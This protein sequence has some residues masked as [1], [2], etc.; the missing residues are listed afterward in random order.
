M[1]HPAPGELVLAGGLAPVQLVA[2]PDSPTP[3][4]DEVAG[5]V[6][7]GWRGRSHLEQ[8]LALGS[9]PAAILMAGSTTEDV[10]VFS[11]L[12][13]LERG[14]EVRLPA[15]H[16]LDLPG[17]THRTSAV[18]RRRRLAAAI[19]WLSSV[20]GR[21]ITPASVQAACEVFAARDAL[22]RVVRDE[23]CSSGAR[24][25]GHAAIVA[26]QAGAALGPVRHLAL[27]RDLVDESFASAPAP[28]GAS[29]RLILSGSTQEE[30]WLYRALERDGLV[31]LGA[32]DQGETDGWT[33]V[34]SDPIG[35]IADRVLDHAGRSAA[36]DGLVVDA[37]VA[38]ARDHDVQTIVHAAWDGDEVAAW[39]AA[40]LTRMAPREMAVV[41]LA[42]APH[43]ARAEEFGSSWHIDDNR[44]GSTIPAAT[45]TGQSTPPPARPTPGA[46]A[47]GTVPRSRKVLAVTDEFSS[48]QREWFQEVTARVRAGEPFAV[49]GADY[50]HEILRAMDI[51]YVVTQWWSSIV[52][53]KRLTASN[54]AALEA[55]GYSTRVEAYSTQ[56][57][58]SHLADEQ[59][60]GG[61]P[62]PDILGATLGTAPTH[63][64]Y[65]AWARETGARY[66]PLERSAETRWRIPVDWWNQLPQQWEE[67]LEAERLD[68]L[69]DEMV[70]VVRGLEA[71]TGRRFD[72]SRFAEVLALANEQAAYYREARDL[73]AATVPAP[74]G[75]VDTMPATMVPQW[76]R[77]TE[78]A[79]D[80]ARSLRDE[81]ADRASRGEGVVPREQLR[82]M[83]VGR[84]LWGD[85]ALYQHLE[86]SHGAVFVWSM[87]LGLAADGYERQ[88]GEGQD[89]LRALASRFVTMGDEL[90]MP[91]WAGAWH[92]KEARQHAVD[93][94][95][96]I[97]DADPFV[98]RSL[99]KAGIPVLRL[100]IENLSTGGEESARRALERFV[101]GLDPAR[102]DPS[103]TGKSDRSTRP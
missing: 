99:E 14:G 27:L 1:G 66:Y 62:A 35:A 47:A 15:C 74:A 3:I 41:T 101:D 60:W 37:L 26:R 22:L 40:R 23:R 38:Q 51:P 88:C 91:T 48:Y 69:R 102:T 53:A 56:G 12:R 24:L 20:A 84:G 100:P 94:A 16:Y 96:A 59:P 46:S 50:P 95:V 32:H 10:R 90:R 31:V 76:H 97:A 67:T 43:S 30:P 54:G 58:A 11:V 44:A 68:L 77:G 89:P 21:E 85:T 65:T 36:S 57:L 71:Q 86:Q 4:L 39:D 6:R 64:I 82:L 79:R 73:L 49:V 61:L 18:Y 2:D 34:P 42:G 55:A 87:Y 45:V 78:W 9:A 13:E 8:I 19:S 81:L 72:E 93:A 83:W 92:V 80:A 17:L 33:H 63:R 5:D 103:S 29:R 28:D 75:V 52:G 25:T 70:G 98:L 7:V